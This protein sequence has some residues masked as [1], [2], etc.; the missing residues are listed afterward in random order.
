MVNNVAT[1]P[2]WLPSAEWGEDIGAIIS[3]PLV[4]GDELLGVLTLAHQE[5]DFFTESHFRLVSTVANELS[6][7]IHNATLYE[8]ITDQAT[9]LAEALKVQEEEA[10]NRE[11]ILELITDGVMV[12]DAA[13]ATQGRVVML[14]PAAE[15]LFGLRAT[16][17]LGRAVP[18]DL[19]ALDA[20]PDVLALLVQVAGLCQF[21]RPARPQQK[22]FQVRD[23]T[24][25]LTLSQVVSPQGA[26]MGGAGR[27]P[28]RDQGSGSG[29]HEERVHLYCGPRA[30]HA[31]DLDQ[32][33]YRPDPDGIGR[34]D[35]RPAAPVPDRN[36]EQRRPAVAAGGR[37]S[38][39][40][41]HRDRAHP[42][43]PAVRRHPRFD[44]R[45][46]GE[47]PE[48]DHGQA[49]N[50]DGAGGDDLPEVKLDRD[51]II[52]VLTNL[53]SNANKYTPEGGSITITAAVRAPALEVAVRDTGYG[54]APQDM[55]RLFT[56]FFR[57]DNPVV[58]F[59]S[60]TGLGLVIARSLVEMHGGRLWAESALGQGSTFTFALPLQLTDDAARREPA[61][62]DGAAG[63]H[64]D[65]LAGLEDLIP[66]AVGRGS[67][68]GWILALSKHGVL[69]PRSIV[70]WSPKTKPISAL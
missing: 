33:L 13:L 46:G 6:I 56:R 61:A 65:S 19:A 31:D 52:Q 28:R 45:R 36:Q 68:R 17:L 32:G 1:D 10:S 58:Q 64:D 22:R 35:Q 8:Y 14:N 16:D 54:I 70:C 9:R 26:I 38:R 62:H 18:G 15:R 53:V 49:A 21:E 59:V 23:R 7:S 41:A 60:G 37:Y 44:R 30:A 24:L 39:P 47:S 34:R 50:P 63:L 5:P 43:E 66:D 42:V 40:V 69:W 2:R 51:R 12:L 4:A 27:L 57:A 48:P 20:E 67:N 11:A 25:T 29:P 3:V 55:E